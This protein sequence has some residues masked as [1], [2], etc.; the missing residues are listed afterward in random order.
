MIVDAVASG[1]SQTDIYDTLN[2][3]GPK[4]VG[5]VLTGI[6]FQ[7]PKGI[8]RTVVDGRQIFQTL[9]GK[10][11]M[12][13]L[14][15]LLEEGRYK[16]PTRIQSVGN[17]F[18]VIAKGLEFLREGVSGTKLVVTVGESKPIVGERPLEGLKSLLR[19]ARTS[20]P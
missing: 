17:R 3:D 4:E 1:A 19:T 12:T 8:K 18:E 11:A 7:V 10:N 20:P 6:Q 13:A 16:L 2:A 15:G 9:G 5:E 14:A